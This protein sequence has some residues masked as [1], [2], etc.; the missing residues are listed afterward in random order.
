MTKIFFALFSLLFLS[1]LD[2]QDRIELQDNGSIQWHLAFDAPRDALPAWP[3]WKAL[4]AGVHLDSSYDRT[5]S[6]G[7]HFGVHVQCINPAATR[8]L[9]SSGLAGPIRQDLDWGKDSLGHLFFTRKLQ[10]LR[11]IPGD[12]GSFADRMLAAI[13]RG[14]LVHFSFHA[15]GRILE[16]FPQ[17]E[18]LDSTQGRVEWNIPLVCLIQSGVQFKVVVAKPSVLS[19]PQVQLWKRPLLIGIA[20]LFVLILAFIRKFHV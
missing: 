7:R 17:A 5:D 11:D 19:I 8:T 13:Y 18:K 6:L 9:D 4:P 16:V 2:I 10:V 12:D 20:V 1:C 3:D 15:P 14:K